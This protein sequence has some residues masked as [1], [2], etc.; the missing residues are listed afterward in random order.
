VLG[1]SPRTDFLIECSFKSYNMA[2]NFDPWSRAMPFWSCAI[3]HSA[4]SW[5]RT[6]PHSPGSWSSAMWHSAGSTYK[7]YTKTSPALCRIPHDHGPALCRIVRD[8]DPALC[9]HVAG[10]HIFV[11]I[12]ANSQQNSKIF[13]S[14]N[15]GP[16]WECLMKKTRDK[17]S[18]D[19]VPFKRLKKMK[20]HDLAREGNV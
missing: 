18:R 9:Q 3:L 14:M 15:Q 2:P 11:Y 17:K 1:K 4:G 7:F 12:S 16:R 10:P 6:M 13:Y 20:V 5:A 8:H 19:T